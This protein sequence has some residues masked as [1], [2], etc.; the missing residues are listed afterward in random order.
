MNDRDKVESSKMK[1]MVL[2]SFELV[3]VEDSNALPTSSS[4]HHE[5]METKH[6]MMKSI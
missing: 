2:G 5:M 3:D 6:N 4:G 1:G